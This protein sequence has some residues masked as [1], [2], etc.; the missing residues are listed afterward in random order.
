M[1]G[2]QD[3][4]NTMNTAGA[5]DNMGG[6][7]LIDKLFGGG[8]DRD[9]A[10]AAMPYYDRIQDEARSRFD[11]YSQRGSDAYDA[12]KDPMDQMTKDPSGFINAL[13]DQYKQSKSSKMQSDEATR[14]AGQSAAAG[15]MR[16][17]VQDMIGQAGI[18][19]RF[20]GQDMQNW[21]GN[22]LGV[23]GRGMAGEQHMYDIGFG[24]DKAAEQS[25]AEALSA[26]GKL[27]REQEDQKKSGGFLDGFG[28]LAGAGLGFAVGGPAG[29][30]IGSQIGGWL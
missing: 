1:P 19:D 23:Q 4:F 24:A 26:Q 8:D 2:F 15:G 25:I 27:A 22:V 16:G 11:P 10:G 13:M 29:A 28:K 5:F 6:G 20:L 21:L 17:S 3:A 14:A 18:A 30:S 9:P 12:M 7:G